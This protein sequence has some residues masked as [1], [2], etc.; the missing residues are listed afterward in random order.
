MTNQRINCAK[1]IQTIL[2]DKVFFAE[3][4]KQISE[5]DL[6]FCNM[7]ILTSLRQWCGLNTVLSHFLQKKIPNK[8]RIAQ[9]LLLA[10]IAEILFM[11]TAPYAVINETVANIKKTCDK[12][13]GG[14]ANAI[15]RKIVDQ[16]EY[17]L[18]E[19]QTIS[20]LPQSFMPILDGYSAKEIKAVAESI[21]QVPPT[22]ITV[23]ANPAEWQNKL[24]GSL[25]PNGSI[26]LQNIKKIHELPE[27]NDG[28]W[29]VQ[30]VAA[31]LPVMTMGDI[32]CLK[33][34][35]LCAAP[36]GKTAQLAARGAKVTAVDISETRLKVLRQN[37]QRLGFDDICTIC[38]DALHFMQITDEKFD[39][40]LLDAPCSATG[41]FRRH[42]EVLHIKTVEDVKKQVQIQQQLLALC[43]NIL[44]PNGVLLYSVCSISK[45]EGEEQIATF[46]RQNPNFKIIPITFKEISDFGSWSDALILPDGT[47]RTLPSYEYKQNGMDSFFICKMQRII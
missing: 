47:I 12:F 38:D 30:D 25:L 17:L 5:K 28:Q 8:H 29:W 7:L 21:Q 46:L 10:A 1:I 34:V 37:L 31:S 36:G 14:M 27:Y 16:K 15:L 4:K 23:K 2:E 19:I 43:K 40:V 42:P 39:A 32:K 24:N 20:P 18:T 45:S 33:V 11:E 13:L 9:Y 6:P 35:D 41:T 44:R 3:L 22:D 26:R